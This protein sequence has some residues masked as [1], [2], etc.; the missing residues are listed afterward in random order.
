M[1]VP[2]G[3]PPYQDP[4]DDWDVLTYSPASDL[5]AY[6]RTIPLSMVLLTDVRL[7]KT[8]CI[9]A[10]DLRRISACGAIPW[11]FRVR[12][13]DLVPEVGAKL[14]KRFGQQTFVG[15][16]VTKW[17]TDVGVDM[18]EVVYTDGDVEEFNWDELRKHSEQYQASGFRHT[19]PAAQPSSSLLS[20][21]RLRRATA[22]RPAA[23]S[24]EERASAARI[25]S[26]A[27]RD[28][29]AHYTYMHTPKTST[30]NAVS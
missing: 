28:T 3:V 11:A 5:V 15:E 7:G 12:K 20:A 10:A 24:E 19:A 1:A 22:R 23:T 26:R 27:A 6:T 16:V 18:Y 17:Q 13:G 4:A 2:P 14:T 29:R 21:K 25:T 30:T 8:G 9:C